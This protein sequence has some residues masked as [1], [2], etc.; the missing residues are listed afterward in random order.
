MKEEDKSKLKAFL[1]KARNDVYYQLNHFTTDGKQ[2]RYEYSFES[3]N[4]ILGLKGVQ[5]L[6]YVTEIMFK[7]EIIGKRFSRKTL[8]REM[9]KTLGQIFLAE[10]NGIEKKTSEILDILIMKLQN[11]TY[12]EWTVVVP[13]VN[14]ELRISSIQIGVV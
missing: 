2:I 14:L 1:L 5:A 3:Y 6:N 8:R 7:D 13:I 12:V 11:S 9:E 10:P 4:I